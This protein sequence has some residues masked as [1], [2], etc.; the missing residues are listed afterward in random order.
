MHSTMDES[1]GRVGVRR[2]NPAIQASKDNFVSEEM[3]V[4][5]TS[6]E[7]TP[8]TAKPV[9]HTAPNQQLVV[10]LRGTLQF[11]TSQGLQF[12]IHAGDVLLAEDTKGSGHGWRIVG[13]DPWRR[14][15]IVLGKDA[16]V[17][18]EATE[19]TKE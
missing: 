7:E 10:T 4:T 17:P 16:L 12:S 11:E 19:Q 18:F 3:E 8:S 9:W 15:Y 14:V 13:D 6:F 2:G 1:K 5:T